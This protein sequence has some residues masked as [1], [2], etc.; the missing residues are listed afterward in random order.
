ML[1]LHVILKNK[2]SIMH[3]KCIATLVWLNICV[4]KFL[5]VKSKEWVEHFC[6]YSVSNE[7]VHFSSIDPSQRYEL[8]KVGALAESELLLTMLKEV[9]QVPEN[10]NTN[11]YNYLYVEVANIKS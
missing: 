9:V 3:C 4:V 1:E 8:T 5:C 6:F 7:P 2:L 11:S 10:V